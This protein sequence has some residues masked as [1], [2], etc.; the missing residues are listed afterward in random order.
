MSDYHR[1]TRE[2][3]FSQFRSELIKAIRD[4]N[5]D[6]HLGDIET[7]A[8]MCCQTTSEKKPPGFWASLLGDEPDKV[9]HTGMLVTP[10]WLVWARSGDKSGTVVSAAK[11]KDIQV[12]AFASRLLKDKG[13]EVYGMIGEA[14]ERMRGYIAL[15]VEEAG[16]KFCEIVRQAVEETR[17]QTPRPKR[18][19][20]GLW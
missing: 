6:H 18:R 16:Q 1:Y 14:R 3:A 7:E 12:K 10:K 8:L 17:Q 5:Q 11:L 15:G 19:I 2:C 4:Y 13:L 9:Y 20:F